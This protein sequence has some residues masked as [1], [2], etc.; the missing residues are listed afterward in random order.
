[1]PFVAALRRSLP[2]A[3]GKDL[4]VHGGDKPG[5]WIVGAGS[6]RAV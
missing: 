5:H 3:A 1:M 6:M 4:T 2:D